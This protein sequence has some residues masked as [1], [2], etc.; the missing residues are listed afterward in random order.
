MKKKIIYNEK[1]FLFFWCRNFEGLLP[2]LYFDRMARQQA[3]AGA[4]GHRR[5]CC[6]ARG[7]C[8]GRA[9]G[10]WALGARDPWC[11]RQ[12]RQERERQADARQGRGRG[13]AAARRARR[14]CGQ[15][16]GGTAWACRGALL[17]TRCARGTAG[18]GVA[19]ALD[20]FTGLASWASFGALCICISLA[21]FF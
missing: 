15:R 2:S 19:W 21:Q 3:R 12:E 13:A 17:G 5:G 6:G 11:A 16:A 10:S 7:A 18:L 1:R 20:G 8:V 14:A 9:G 4:L